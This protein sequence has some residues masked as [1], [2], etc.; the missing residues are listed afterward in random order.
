M[1]QD[2]QLVSSARNGCITA[3][4]TFEL[5]IGSC[6]QGETQR[7]TFPVAS[8][9][10]VGLGGL[11]LGV[12]DVR[13]ADGVA[14]QLISCDSR[15]AQAWSRPA[16]G[17]V[18]SLDKCLDVAGAGSANG[19]RVQL[20]TCNGTAAQAWNFHA[21]GTILNPSS[22]KCLDV[23]DR[24][25]ENGTQ[26]Q[27]WDCFGGENQRWAGPVWSPRDGARSSA[28]WQYGPAA[29]SGTIRSDRAGVES[30]QLFLDGATQ[31]T[32]QGRHGTQVSD[33]AMH[34]AVTSVSATC[35]SVQLELREVTAYGAAG[36]DATTIPSYTI[37]LTRDR[38]EK[39]VTRRYC[40]IAASV[41]L[42]AGPDEI[43]RRLNAIL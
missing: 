38:T 27:I 5:G 22:G 23:T 3:T 19:T 20:Y 41:R 10:V 28:D 33:G 15:G 6:G 24:R 39:E 43:A 29:F 35:S 30:G 18:R 42:G 31:G 26:L 1:G 14:A 17:T 7:F 32:V 11:C 25:A 16:D 13:G 37:T 2:D 12:A 8:G 9:T 4:S 36:G 34:S 21:D 40:A